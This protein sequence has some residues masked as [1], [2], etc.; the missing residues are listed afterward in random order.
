M[1]SRN[2]L[3]Q[4]GTSSEH[5]FSEPC[6]KVND[7][8]S[9]MCL[10]SEVLPDKMSLKV[11]IPPTRHDVIHACDIYEDVAI[12]YGY[13]NIKRTI[14]NT[15]TIG[16]QLDINKLTELLRSPIAECEFTEALTFSLVSEFCHHCKC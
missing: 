5:I 13:N 16:Q 10:T 15:N 11:T 1:R 4:R 8:L 3:L 6:E 9:K 12:A 14:P 7:L 2:N